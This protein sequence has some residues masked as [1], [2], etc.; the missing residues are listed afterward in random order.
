M[1]YPVFGT[2]QNT[3]STPQDEVD[4]ERGFPSLKGKKSR[5]AIR[6]EWWLAA[7]PLLF[8]L[9]LPVF[10]LLTRSSIS[11]LLTTAADPQVLTAIKISFKTTLISLVIIVLFGTPVA[12]ILGRGEFKGKKL[13]ETLVDLPTV[14][15]PSV[16]GVALLLALGRRGLVG[17]FLAD[18]GLQIPFSQLAVILAQLFIAAPYFIRSAV[19]GFAA[20]D[21][22]VLE[23]GALD[24]AN[25]LQLFRYIIIP[26]SQK[27]IITGAVMSWARALGEFGATIIFAG[28]FIGVTQ[29]MPLAIY[30]GF[31]MNLELA[32][33]LSVILVLVSFITLLTV[34]FFTD[35]K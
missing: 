19:I 35:Q 26:V 13:V 14:L 6:F 27:S 30:L 32:I 12:F 28:N 15:P 11:E 20:V 34:R 2:S 3:R 7:L 5:H 23:A 21:D 17:G 18:L 24:G 4:L 1:S 9:A 16:A 22:E 8:F 29:T 31:E 10:A 25:Q 33:T